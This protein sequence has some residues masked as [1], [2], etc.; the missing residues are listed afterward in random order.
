MEQQGSKP[1]SV[2]VPQAAPKTLGVGPAANAEHKKMVMLF[3]GEYHFP[4]AEH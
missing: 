2:D 4:A 1:I 3:G